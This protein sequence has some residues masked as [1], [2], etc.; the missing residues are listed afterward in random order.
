MVISEAQLNLWLGSYLWPL[1]RVGAMMLATPVFNSRQLPVQLRLLVLLVITWVIALS[2]PQ[3]PAI[4]VLSHDGFIIML[5]QILIGVIMGFILQMVFGA[6]VFG[7]QVAAWL[8]RHEEFELCE[9][10]SLFPPDCGTDGGY[11]ALLRKGHRHLSGA[12]SGF[13]LT[14]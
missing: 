10:R 3:Q 11:C 5:Q 14:S 6:L 13:A 8:A 4:D 7:G 2:L 9:E 12:A 1:M